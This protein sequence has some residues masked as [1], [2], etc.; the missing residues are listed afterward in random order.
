MASQSV[1][2][3]PVVNATVASGISRSGAVSKLTPQVQIESKIFVVVST[4]P[5]ITTT[6]NGYSMEGAMVKPSTSR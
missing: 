6:P 2:A 1:M 3:H 5:I 4:L